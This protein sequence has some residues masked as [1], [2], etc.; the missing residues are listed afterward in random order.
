MIPPNVRTMDY[1]D[2]YVHSVEDPRGL[3]EAARR[4][5]QFLREVNTEIEEHDIPVRPISSYHHPSYRLFYHLLLIP[6]QSTIRRR[7]DLHMFFC[8]VS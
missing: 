2:V 1:V 5:I 4:Y 3:I 6:F 8:P 7:K